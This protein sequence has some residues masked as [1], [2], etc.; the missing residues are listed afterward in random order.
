MKILHQTHQR[1]STNKNRW[2]IW[3]M[4]TTFQRFMVGEI[5]WIGKDIGDFVKIDFFDKNRFNRFAPPS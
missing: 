1:Q 3:G 4:F 2:Y 5:Y